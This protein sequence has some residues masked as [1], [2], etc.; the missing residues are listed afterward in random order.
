MNEEK[1]IFNN[2]IDFINLNKNKNN[3]KTLS[4][5][6]IE[7]IVDK[8]YIFNNSQIGEYI[9]KFRNKKQVENIFNNKINNIGNM[10]LLTWANLH[11]GTNFHT[12]SIPYNSSRMDKKSYK[13]ENGTFDFSDFIIPSEFKYTKYIYNKGNLT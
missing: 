4:N 6:S 3:Y 1:I 9:I 2:L 13:L 10:D 5:K 12:D 11:I 8:G 7:F